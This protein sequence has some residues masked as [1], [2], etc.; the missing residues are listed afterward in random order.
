MALVAPVT[1][2]RVCPHG[3]AR[4]TVMLLA[5]ACIFTGCALSDLAL[6]LGKWEDGRGSVDFKLERFVLTDSFAGGQYRITGTYGIDPNKYPKRVDF[7][8]EKISMT[9]S[10]EELNGAALLPGDTERVVRDLM[11]RVILAAQSPKDDTAVRL[12]AVFAQS[13]PERRTVQGI[14]AVK[15]NSGTYLELELNLPADGRPEEYGQG[16]VARDY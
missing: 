13:I 15:T 3:L 1:R 16:Y 9:S 11:Q 8:L 10:E 7:V 6:W 12:L 5:A 2:N 14:Y 4:T